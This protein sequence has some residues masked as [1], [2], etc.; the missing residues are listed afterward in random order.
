MKTRPKGQLYQV[1]NM[2]QSE[3]K[4]YQRFFQSY[5]EQFASMCDLAISQY[6]RDTGRE[7]AGGDGD[8]RNAVQN[9]MQEW[10]SRPFAP[11]YPDLTGD[12]LIDTLASPADAI[13]FAACAAAWC[14][15]ELPDPIRIKLSSFGPG[16]SEKILASINQSAWENA[17]NRTAENEKGVAAGAS[18][19][20]LLGDWGYKWGLASVL[21]G[22]IALNQPDERI[23]DAIRYYIVALGGQ[24]I[25]PV[26]DII[27]QELEQQQ[28]LRPAA[29]YLLIALTDLGKAERSDDLFSCLRSCFRK[30][31]HKTIGAICLGDYGD[32]RGIAVLKGWLDSH[33]EI[34]DRQLISE[35]LSSI[36]RL[37]GDISD[38]QHRLR[39]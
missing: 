26:M 32:G 2:N 37:G 10:F 34:Y 17:G 35:I 7:W 16:I 19:L 31:N 1:K 38:L 15:D 11:E 24:A 21:D 3:E 5:N 33:P 39:L 6:E 28:D 27:R 23:A 14:D 12:Q 13:E 18:F 9:N 20:K 30:M 29:E 8:L 25:L 4:K 36:R 22:F